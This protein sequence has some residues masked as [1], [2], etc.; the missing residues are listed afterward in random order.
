MKRRFNYI[1]RAFDERG[2]P[3]AGKW[4]SPSVKGAMA[5]ADGSGRRLNSVQVR[6]AYTSDGTFWGE[7]KGRVVAERGGGRWKVHDEHDNLT[8]IVKEHG[9]PQR[10]ARDLGAAGAFA[11]GV[12][13]SIAGDAIYHRY[14]HKERD[15]MR[16]KRRVQLTKLARQLICAM[17]ER[18]TH[19]E[20]TRAFTEADDMVWRIWDKMSDA[21]HK[22]VAHW[23]KAW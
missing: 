4:S 20:G 8:E 18:D 6:A 7:G 3:I 17:A 23:L 12:A 11:L 22:K 10:A 9:R 19:K 2:Q 21:D 13:S 5:L 15:A 16:T 1:A 14:V